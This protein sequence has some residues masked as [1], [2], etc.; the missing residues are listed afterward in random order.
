MAEIAA[1][2]AL[3]SGTGLRRRISQAGGATRKRWLREPFLHFILLGGALFLVGDYLEQRSRFTQI[4]ISKDAVRGIADN[5][6]LQYGHYPTDAQLEALV[7]GYTREEVFYHEAQKLG[8]DQDD[9]IVR[10][11]LVQKY[12]FLQQ[13]LAVADNPSDIDVRAYFLAHADR[14]TLPPTVA[15]SQ[16]FF[17]VDRRGDDNAKGAASSASLKL[18]SSG[19][20]RAPAEGD[21]FPG[22]E[23]YS[24]LS[25][26][27]AER[28]FG[29]GGLTEALFALTP[30]QWSTP[31]RSAYGWHIIRV[32]AYAPSRPAEFDAVREQVRRDYIEQMRAERNE[33]NYAQLKRNF[34]IV[35]E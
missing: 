25:A 11:R 18:N 27:D 9:E 16:V 3:P 23:D 34:K 13:D 6:R 10:R 14:Y 28:V 31:L 7:E 26:Q 30:G 24:G 29:K 5:Y 35:R 32:E 22:P 2:I 8:L 15:F 19:T 33:V 1:N 21:S 4:V 17:S 12:E 20:V